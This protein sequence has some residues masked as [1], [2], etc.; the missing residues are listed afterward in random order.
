M[1]GSILPQRPAGPHCPAVQTGC[2]LK[3]LR[4]W[5]NH[6]KGGLIQLLILYIKNFQQRKFYCYV[7]FVF[8]P[9]FLCGHTQSMWKFPGSGIKPAPQQ[10]PEQWH[11]RC[12][13]LNLE[14]PLLLFIIQLD[15]LFPFC[16]SPC[17]P[18]LPQSPK[19][20]VKEEPFTHRTEFW[21]WTSH[22]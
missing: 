5:M 17:P 3:Q 15:H 1:L 14:T 10:W 11:R 12:W 13:I 22:S 18:C 20:Y 19:N 9:F 16:H 2:P 8:F 6:L 4:I 21:S 7:V